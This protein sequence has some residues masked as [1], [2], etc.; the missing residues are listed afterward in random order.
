MNS[1]Y[2]SLKRYL[3]ALPLSDAAVNDIL[4]CFN[5]KTYNRGQC[6]ARAGDTQDKH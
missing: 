4:A 3:V 1:T 6:F 2:L 5:V